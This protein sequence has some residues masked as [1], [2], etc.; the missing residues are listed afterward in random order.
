MKKR[1]ATIK[2]GATAATVL[3]LSFTLFGLPGNC[4]AEAETVNVGFVFGVTGPYATYGV[5][6]RDAMNWA[7]SEIDKKGGFEVN[8]KKYKLNVIY[9]DHASKPEIEGPGLLKKA[10]FSDNVP[11]VFLGGSPITRI[12]IPILQ[13]AKTPAV[14]ILA[15]MLGVA[16]QSPY[17]FRIR[18]DAAQ[19]APPMGAYFRDM[20][21][22]RLTC[23]GSDTDFSRDQIAIWKDLVKKAGGEILIEE[24][25]SPGKVQDFYPSLSKIK[26]LNPDAGFVAGTTQQNALVYKQAREVGLTIPLGG[27]T[28]MTPEQAKDLIGINYNDVLKNVLDARGIDPGYHPAKQVRDWS[29]QF[30]DKFGYSPADLTM[31]A[32]DAPYI[33]IEA[34]KKA[35]SVTDKEK[36]MKALA[37]LAI[38]AGMLT[39][40]IPMA[41]NKLFDENGQAYSTTVVLGWKDGGWEAK[42]YYA[43]VKDVVKEIHY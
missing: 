43:V 27:Y 34:F 36:L 28:G 17:L 13:R 31:W 9:Y 26:S 41:G 22:K 25:Y 1:R 42:K 4:F 15:G 39:P 38:P 40:F 18:P 21:F 12:S 32:W 30:Q 16:E 5:P 20:G 29:K 3:A 8:G 33:A 24:Y 7:L 6:M 14:V 35:Q 23:F 37:D 2:M 11:I 19:C 10:L